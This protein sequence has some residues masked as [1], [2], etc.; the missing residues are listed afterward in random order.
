MVTSLL[1]IVTIHLDEMT[2]VATPIHSGSEFGRWSCCSYHLRF[3]ILYTSVPVLLQWNLV[4][5][6]CISNSIS[7]TDPLQ[8]AYSAKIL[9]I[10]FL[11]SKVKPL[12]GQ[13]LFLL[14]ASY[15]LLHFSVSSSGL[16]DSLIVYWWNFPPI[17]FHSWLF[18]IYSVFPRFPPAI[19]VYIYLSL[20]KNYYF[21]S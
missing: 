3:P 8:L 5:T 10:Y 4:D 16:I 11:S 9:C 18:S 21:F 17:P 6:R 12:L 14:S 7:T 15:S 1:F 20:K 2:T 19:D 13:H